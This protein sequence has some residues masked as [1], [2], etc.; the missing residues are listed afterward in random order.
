MDQL[1]SPAL[2]RSRLTQDQDRCVT[3][4]DE[5]DLLVELGHGLGIGRQLRVGPL[6]PFPRLQVRR[7]A[8]QVHFFVRPIGR[9]LQMLNIHGLRQEVLSP[10]AHSLHGR[11]QIRLTREHD[12]R[13]VRI[14]STQLGEDVQAAHI[15]KVQIED[16]EVGRITS[17][18]VHPSP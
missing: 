5:G 1:C 13:D 7:P 17:V 3:G 11:F 15:W 6:V 10:R 14:H 2:S 16:D 4:R 18:G 9:R 8:S 12:H